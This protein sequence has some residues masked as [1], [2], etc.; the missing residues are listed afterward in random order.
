MQF[1]LMLWDCTSE[2]FIGEG[3]L[4]KC[5][6]FTGEY[7]CQS[8]SP[9]SVPMRE[10]TE[11]KNSV[12]EHISHSGIYRVSW[13]IFFEASLEMCR[14]RSSFQ[15]VFLGEGVLKILRKLTG[16]HPCW[17]AKRSAKQ[18]YWNFLLLLTWNNNLK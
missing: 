14:G 5:S 12:F 9:Y 2:V 1:D 4:K 15:E 16:E 18:L 13:Q 7:P 3:V 6:K 8:I 17:S 10:N 11:Q